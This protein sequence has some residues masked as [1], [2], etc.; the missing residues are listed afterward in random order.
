MIYLGLLSPSNINYDANWYHLSLAQDYARWGAIRPA[1]NTYNNC[2]PH[3]ATIL[4]TW[5]YL[6]PGLSRAERW[7]CAQHIEFCLFLW[8]LVAV[9]AAVQRMVENWSLKASWVAFFLFPSIFV[10]DSNLGTAADHVLAF[11]SV[12]AVIATLHV[13][14]NFSK[15]SCALL[16]ITLAGAALTKYQGFYIVASV[17]VVV[18]VV[19]LAAWVRVLAAKFS[20]GIRW[21][22]A[23]LWWAPLVICTLG[24][25]LTLPHFLKNY[26]FY[27]NPV[28]PFLLDVFTK[29]HPTMPDARLAAERVFTLQEFVPQGTLSTKLWHA[30][31]IFFTFSFVPHYASNKGIP[32]FGSLFTLLLPCLILVPARRAIV[33]GT[34]VAAGCILLWGM[35]FNVD[36]NLQTFMPIMVC[37][38]AALIVKVWHLGWFARVGLIPLVAT[39]VISTADLPFYAA[40]SRIASSMDLARSG[41]EGH[42]KT[43]FDDFFKSHVAINQALP[44]S[45]TLLI[46]DEHLNLGIDR[47]ILSDIEGMQGL[48]SFRHLHTP[49]EVYDYFQSLGITH[50]LDEPDKVSNQSRQL[51]VLYYTFIE[52]YAAV[53]PTPGDG[54]RL[55]NM[56]AKP[57]PVE[58]PY[59]VLCMKVDTYADGLYP[60]DTLYKY[61]PIP[62]YLQAYATPA[63]P[64]V[65]A[66]AMELLHDASAALL[67]E[68]ADT[69][70]IAGEL[71]GSFERVKKLGNIILYVRRP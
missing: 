43:R 12:P 64:L 45:A 53:M 34:A 52:R 25:L 50:I 14:R 6:L 67:S 27:G 42:A 15:G 31:K 2:V 32:Y 41:Y 57:P 70:A 37:V 55:M 54:Y 29:S 35:T 21:S 1:F 16:A 7:M 33:I 4:Y 39:Q 13:C 63:R 8:T 61:S 17:A 38:A 5:G 62:L 49:R 71:S 59:R 69:S 22:R 26:I 10:Y 46:H 47:D 66:N 18:A 65:G 48:V 60:V 23:E 11:F 68:S 28:Y 24:V 20:R 36:R 19:W 30:I 51:Q 58:A 40:Y 3:L 44:P 56:P 9:V